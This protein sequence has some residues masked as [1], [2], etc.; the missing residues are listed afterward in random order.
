MNNSLDTDGATQTVAKAFRKKVMVVAYGRADRQCGYSHRIKELAHALA[1]GGHDVVLLWMTAF[2]RARSSYQFDTLRA[3]A[4]VLIRPTLPIGR[5]PGFTAIGRW[6]CSRTIRRE[7]R[8]HGVEIIQA[9]TILA[10]G[11]VLNARISLPL[12]VDLHGD[13]VPVWRAQRY[14]EWSIRRIAHDTQTAYRHAAGLLVVSERLMHKVNVAAKRPLL[15]LCVI[16]CG[17]NTERFDLPQATR[18]SMRHEIRLHD[19]IVLCYCGSLDTWQCITETLAFAAALTRRRVQTALMILTRDDISPWQELLDQIGRI[20]HDYFII[21][22][23]P[24]EVPLYLAAADMGLL[25]RREDPVNEVA[26]PTKLGEYLAAGVPVAT[27]AFAGDAPAILAGSGCGFIFDSTAPS[28]AEWI[29]FE[30]FMDQSMERRRALSAE[31]KAIALKKHNW[32]TI[33]ERLLSFYQSLPHA[34]RP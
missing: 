3:V 11:L 21:N 6:I 27:T 8:A 15:P 9:E 22:A 1:L 26:S 13:H 28:E 29:T 34:D 19:R 25:L 33:S 30:A 5:L 2:Y 20:N 4:T 24:S 7:A 16:P 10:A 17:V 31:C 12:V 14:P 32:N 23:E 18:E